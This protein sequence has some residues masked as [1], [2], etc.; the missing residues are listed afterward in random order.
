MLA[1]IN[2]AA[3]IGLDAYPIE[4]EAHLENGLP[5]L[6]IV[7]L[8]D[9]SV[10]ESKE[11]I[12]AAIKNSYLKFPQKKITINL[13]PANIKK[14]GTAYDLPIAVALL[15]ASLQI[16]NENI[17]DYLFVGE[18]ALDGSLR[19]IKGA[20]SIALMAK[21]KNFK[22]IILPIDNVKEAGVIEGVEILGARSLTE[23][24]KFLAGEQQILP[25]KTDLNKVFRQ[26]RNYDLDFSEVKGQYHVKRS[27][28]VAAA[29]GHNVLM[30]GPPGSGKSMLSKRFCTILPD[31]SLDEALETTKI[32]SVS[33][34]LNKND[35]LVATR[36]F[37]SPHHSI[38]DSALVGGGRI[39]RPGEISLSHNGVLFLD[40]LPEFKKNV[41][42][43][44][45]QPLE[46][47]EVTIARAATTLKFPAGFMLIAAMNPCPCGYYGTNQ[48]E[49]RC[50]PHQIKAYR[51]KISGPLLDRIDIHVE[52]P[53]VKYEDL[54]TKEQGEKSEKI[55][56]RVIKARA[57]QTKRY[58]GKSYYSNSA[59]TQ[60]DLKDYCSLDKSSH[61]ILKK[62][63]EKLSLSAR[64]YNRIIK[65]S[66]TIADLDGKKNIEVK[67]L[68]EA[69]QYRSLD[70]S[71][72]N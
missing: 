52:V 38:S 57:I 16:E 65:V 55:R 67:H 29:G 41:L 27:L 22:A 56:E 2:S 17:N 45:R 21:K 64:A 43:V 40:E 71:I 61:E 46:D 13:A 18:L 63:I 48:Q 19:A 32:Y 31:M 10:K 70:R 36:P 51:N 69:I 4:V 66:R 3:V 62:A 42:E 33:G 60:K 11:R 68:T 28:E 34:L 25:Y 39:P 35:S 20:L 58:Q 15:C 7:G 37:R 59:M 24:Q 26:N 5:A 50:S 54:A 12:N 14:E 23:V 9:A 47:R 8:P 30:I 49:C 44:M 6:A 1:K 53:L 72:L